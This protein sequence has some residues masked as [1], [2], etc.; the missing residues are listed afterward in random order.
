MAM[1][2]PL[3]PSDEE[4]LG[5]MMAGDADAF[6]SL[7]DRRQPSVYRFALRM[8]GSPTLATDITQ[9]VFLAL[10]R[11]GHQFDAT[12]GS[13]TAYLLGITRHR[14]LRVLAKERTVV[15]LSS[16]RGASRADDGEND[17]SQHEDLLVDPDE[18][19]DHL[20]KREVVDAVRQ[21]VFAL[22]VHYREVVVL[23]N[24]QEMSYEQTAAIVG[25]PVG[26]VRSRLNRARAI[27]A[28]RLRIFEAN[29]TVRCDQ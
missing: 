16:G 5:R 13:L 21:A 9:D 27:L 25:C 8:S 17:V 18:P 19:I 10:M 11:D 3:E 23:C 2:V 28:E 26:T 6:E 22:P 14:V 12:R 20:L 1:R 4:L 7:Y 15:S 24:L 29:T